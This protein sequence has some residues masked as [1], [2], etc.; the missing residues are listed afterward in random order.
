MD[1]L[2]QKVSMLIA[3]LQMRNRMLLFAFERSSCDNG[4]EDERGEWGWGE[5]TNEADPHHKLTII[6]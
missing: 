2:K 5:L 6:F 1:H 3:R 4:T